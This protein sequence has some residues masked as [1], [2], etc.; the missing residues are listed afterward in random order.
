MWRQLS[1]SEKAKFVGQ[2]VLGVGMSA[3]AVAL[4]YTTYQAYTMWQTVPEV[5]AQLEKTSDRIQPALKEVEAVR[6]LVP[7]I[8]NEVKEVRSLVTPVLAEIKAVREAVPPVL[9]E[10]KSVREAL[11]P[12]LKTSEAS[13]R[14]ASG[15]IHALEPHIKPVIEEVKN[16]REALPEIIDQADR[17]V[18]RASTAGKEAG[19]GAVHGVL[20]GIILAPFKLIGDVGMGVFGLMG[21]GDQT[22][23]TAED[24]RLAAAATQEVLKTPKASAKR[25]WRNAETRNN[26]SVTITGQKERDGMAFVI[27]R[28]HVVLATKK[29]HDADVEMCRQPDGT[30]V[31]ARPASE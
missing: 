20:G 9:V 14:E 21:L 27:L 26:G 31:G 24:E 29:T 7:P 18:G 30:W 25:A 11:P 13:I 5:M 12:M 2:T 10:V 22:G 6:N 23:L 28:H 4:I 19:Q 8:L 15:A 1:S 16:T 3:L 17:V